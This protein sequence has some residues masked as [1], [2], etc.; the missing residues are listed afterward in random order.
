MS[1]DESCPPIFY[2]FIRQLQK[3][4]GPSKGVGGKA[5]HSDS[6]ESASQKQ[7]T[8]DLNFKLLTSYA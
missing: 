8:H 6:T 2:V 7:I 5:K 1:S 4:F 3:W